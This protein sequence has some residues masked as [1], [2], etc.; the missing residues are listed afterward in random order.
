[1]NV[2][3]KFAEKYGAKG[4]LL[5]DDPARSAPNGTLV[6]PQSEYLPKEG[7]QRGTLYNSDGDPTTPNYPSI[8]F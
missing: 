7:V 8:G 1:M 3:V 2:K 4:V 6:Y 5:Y